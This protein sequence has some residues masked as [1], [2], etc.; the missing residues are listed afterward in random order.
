[1]KTYTTLFSFLLMNLTHSVA[2]QGYLE[3]TQDDAIYDVELIVFARQLS[4][5]AAEQFKQA[6]SLKTADALQLPVWDE[7]TD[8]IQYPEPEEPAVDK[9]D[10]NWQVP[11]EEQ[12]Q[13]VNVLSWLVLDNSLNHP[14]ID[15]LMVNPSNQVLLRQKWR[16]PASSFTAPTYVEVSTIPLEQTADEAANEQLSFGDD[17]TPNDAVQSTLFE[18]NASVPDDFTIDGQVAFSEQRFTHLHVKLNLYRINAMGESLVYEISQQRR[19]NLEEWHYFDHQQFGVLAKV[20]Q[21]NLTAEQED[22]ANN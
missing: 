13:A 10:E 12:S 5:P 19:I 6:P 20:T 3:L 18:Q 16:Q 11:I 15:Q 8:L 22:E 14:I 7:E 2:A 9:Q 1:M 21:V 17:L 4:Q